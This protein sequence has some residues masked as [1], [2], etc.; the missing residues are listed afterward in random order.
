MRWLELAI[1]LGVI[2]AGAELFTNGVEWVGEG[3]GLSEGAVG[4]VLAAIGTALPET[5]L[6]LVAVLS[7]HE[8]G[9][10]IGVGAILGAPFMIS[11]LAMAIL[12]VVVLVTSA[13]GS[14]S[15]TLEHD[16][17]V[18]AQDL[19]F[20]LVLYLLATVAGIVHVEA[21]KWVL[22]GVL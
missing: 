1:A 15:R 12:G 21:F 11:T 10:E 9:D 6:P 8:K 14:R 13:R 22:A 5:I 3:F 17:G 4:S 18:L 19:E 20:F 16:G 2:L 7:G